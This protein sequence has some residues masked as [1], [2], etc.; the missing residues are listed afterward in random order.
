[1]GIGAGNFFSVIGRYSPKYSGRDAMSTYFRCAAEL[2][3]PGLALLAIL[4][5]NAFRVLWRC[6]LESHGLQEEREINFII[7]GLQVCLV[8][9]AVSGSFITMAYTEELFIFLL[10][11]VCLQ[12]AIR[13]R[14]R[15]LQG[16]IPGEAHQRT[17]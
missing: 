1:M 6:R 17:S 8:V 10:L 14:R 15:E 5:L 11:P 13:T 12:R 7:I 9:F 4:F 2:G 16:A 3:I